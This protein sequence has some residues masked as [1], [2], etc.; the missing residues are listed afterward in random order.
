MA[1]TE[2]SREKRRTYMRA[3]LRK[4]MR[5]WR[6]ANR[7][8]ARELAVKCHQ[9]WAAA[10]PER[11]GYRA[12]K[13]RA[14][15]RNIEFLLTFEEWLTIWLESGKLAQR[16]T[17]SLDYC[18]ARHGDA[19]PYAIG[20]V[21]ICTNR[22]NCAE[23]KQGKT[24]SK[25]TRERLSISHRGKSPSEAQRKAISMTLKARWAKLRQVSASRPDE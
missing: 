16:G 13:N 9:R 23:A 3:Y 10:N 1:E 21:R 2:D 12:H 14:A 22:E 19:G 4:Y 5:E 6:A 20:N 18:M 8:K 24:V 15:R 7:E 17:G 11:Y 25:E